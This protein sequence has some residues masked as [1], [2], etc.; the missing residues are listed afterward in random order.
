[1]K[2]KQEFN[3]VSDWTEYIGNYAESKFLQECARKGYTVLSTLSVK[4]YD[5]V[6]ERYTKQFERIQIKA[7]SKVNTSQFRLR[8]RGASL[9]HSI[10][11]ADAFD[12]LAM[13]LVEY[14]RFYYV[15][16]EI[17]IDKL[18]D[19]VYIVD[20]ELETTKLKK[21]FDVKNYKNW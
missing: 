5:F 16:A 13:Y 19:G 12:H 21:S 1:M 2:S 3:S 8:A 14:D 18:N 15:P 4:P 20:S 9:Y 7:L 17:M 6:I 10:Y 11:K